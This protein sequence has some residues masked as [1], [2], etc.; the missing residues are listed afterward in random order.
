MWS[1]FY[2]VIH[3][4]MFYA[5]R[6]I[7]KVFSG[8]ENSSTSKVLLLLEFLVIF[9]RKKWNVAKICEGSKSVNE[10]LRHAIYPYQWEVSSLLTG[11]RYIEFLR[12]G[13][14][15]S[16]TAFKASSFFGYFSCCQSQS[17][18]CSLL[19]W[20]GLQPGVWKGKTEKHP[21]CKAYTVLDSRFLCC[22][23]SRRT[24]FLRQ[25]CFRSAKV[26]TSI[27]SVHTWRATYGWHYHKNNR[28][29]LLT[30]LVRYPLLNA[31]EKQE[32]VLAVNDLAEGT[33]QSGSG[34]TS[35][36]CIELGDE[37]RFKYTRIRF[38]KYKE[39]DGTAA[40]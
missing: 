40:R 5:I 13:R 14:R 16:D 2:I 1:V 39:L 19:Q 31:I 10:A 12:T 36:G 35:N 6:I 21:S 22:Y 23:K 38:L 3:H 25:V 28:Q 32:N 11:M 27:F 37:F 24:W 29:N 17:L 26:G 4:L 7:A 9:M 20:R 34:K 18:L 8:R 33:N 30:N 15:F